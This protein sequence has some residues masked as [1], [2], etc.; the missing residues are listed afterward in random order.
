MVFLAAWEGPERTLAMQ[1]YGQEFSMHGR[2]EYREPL[3]VMH[4]F[5]YAGVLF[6][7]YPD[8]KKRDG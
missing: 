7:I 8:K 4:L 6:H 3:T 1:S 5:I 2:W